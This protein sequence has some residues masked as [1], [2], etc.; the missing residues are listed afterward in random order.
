[1]KVLHIDTEQGW[2]GGEAQALYLCQ[3]LEKQGITS[4]IVAPSGSKFAE[5]SRESG[6]RVVVLP[7]DKPYDLR[8]IAIIRKTL[9]TERPILVH[10][11]TSAAHSLALLATIG[12]RSIP[13]VVS[14]RVDFRISGT[15]FSRW[16]YH[17]PRVH[18]IAISRG[19]KDVLVRGGV[20][21]RHIDIVPS[22]IELTRLAE[23]Q[24]S[25]SELRAELGISPE[26]FI[27][28]NVGALTDHKGHRYLIDAAKQVTQK[29]PESV[30]LIAGEGEERPYLEKQ[31]SRLQL[32]QQV[33]LLGF[34]QDVI[35]IMR[36]FN[37]FVVSSHLEGLCTSMLDAMAL[38]I[39]VIA[40]RTGGIP[41]AVIDRETGMLVE[42]KNPSTL[43][44]A[45]I[46]AHQ[47]PEEMRQMAERASSFVRQH[48]S[49]DRM[50]SETINVYKKILGENC[51]FS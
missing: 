40:T 32:R 41:D 27:I 50:V 38:G 46:Y 23:S 9:K 17:H 2:R 21:D 43:A 37:L 14:R 4:V 26:A 16:K 33:R 25:I 5:R 15:P 18:Y 45:I 6:F 7:S 19:V 3:G 44:E 11:H 29:I 1:M 36:V 39:P 22:G 47:H 48:F 35:E 13:V 20:E 51:R 30:F 12:K 42:P 31:I 28:G 10:C 34:R 8:S 49:V 24:K